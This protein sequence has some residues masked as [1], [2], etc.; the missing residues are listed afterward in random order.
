MTTGKLDHIIVDDSN[1]EIVD[2]FIFLGVIITN[3]GFNDK[4]LRIRLAMGTCAMEVWNVGNYIQ[5]QR[6]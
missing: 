4:E 3:D 6:H 1:I 5:R 2:R